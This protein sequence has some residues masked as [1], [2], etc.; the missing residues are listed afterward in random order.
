VR[1]T[2]PSAASNLALGNHPV[3]SS[4]GVSAPRSLPSMSEKRTPGGTVPCHRP[5]PPALNTLSVTWPLGVHDRLH[6][7]R[8]DPPELLQEIMQNALR[9]GSSTDHPPSRRRERGRMRPARRAV[10]LWP[11][12]AWHAGWIAPL[13]DARARHRTVRF[14]VARRVRSVTVGYLRAC[15]QVAL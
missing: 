6:P 14:E 2:A 13:R 4:S 3:R 7:R 9:L 11:Q 1:A 12:S 5:R 15:R 8:A 10:A